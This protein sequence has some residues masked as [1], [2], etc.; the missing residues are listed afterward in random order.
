MSILEPYRVRSPVSAPPSVL[1]TDCD[2]LTMAAVK[3]ILRTEG[4]KGLVSGCFHSPSPSSHSTPNVGT[5]TG[6]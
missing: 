3:I 1:L 5:R 2:S 6:N 4:I